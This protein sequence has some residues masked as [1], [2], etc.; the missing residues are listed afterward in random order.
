MGNYDTHKVKEARPILLTVVCGY[1]ILKAI[2]KTVTA[3]LFLIDSKLVQ[4]LSSSDGF[5]IITQG[6]KGLQL[7]MIALS[8]IAV[9][10][11][12]RLLNF[13]KSGYTIYIGVIIASYLA[14][15]FW[16]VENYRP[17]MTEL[18]LS[19]I[20]MLLLYRYYN[21]MDGKG[22]IGS[23]YLADTLGK[24]QDW[25]WDWVDYNHKNPGKLEEWY[26]TATQEELITFYK[27][28]DSIARQ[29]I[30]NQQGIYIESLGTY[31]SEDSMDSL[32]NWIIAQ[33]K[34]LWSVS[35]TKAAAR[36]NYTNPKENPEEKI[37]DT[38]YTIYSKSKAQKQQNGPQPITSWQGVSWQTRYQY[39]PGPNAEIIYKERFG[40][41][42]YNA[43]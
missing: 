9:F 39:F 3:F 40:E 5:D 33:G 23:T 20:P 2:L 8:G 43:F 38:L 27:K 24:Q 16:G 37:W 19:A 13:K 28:Y 18:T 11:A 34:E 35:A 6:G 41:S 14:P 32:N 30:P 4:S 22:L 17:T 31:L 29:L 1:I 36:S 21:R 15:I 10:A 12:I 7:S 25:F 26:K 42:I